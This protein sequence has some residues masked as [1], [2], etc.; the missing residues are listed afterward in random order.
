M[1]TRG[2]IAIKENGK[3]K[4]V[5]NQWDSYI[6]NLGITLYKFYKEVDKVKELINLGDLSSVG[7]TI[8]NNEKSYTEFMNLTGTE[9]KYRGTVSFYREGRE[10]ND[11]PGY[12]PDRQWDEVK[13]RETEDINEVLDEEFTYIFDV[14]KDKWYVAYDR[15]NF[16]IRELEHVLHKIEIVKKFADLIGINEKYKEEFYKKCLSA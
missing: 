1:A 2:R 4:Y 10:W 14:D 8:E 3:Y 15:D 5:Y 16:E 11:Y 13:P 6:D 12:N 9:C 7:C